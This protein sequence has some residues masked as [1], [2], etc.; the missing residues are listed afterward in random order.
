M[1]KILVIA[2]ASALAACSSGDATSAPTE[3]L[4][5]LDVAAGAPS[6]ANPA[7]SFWAVSGQSRRLRIYYQPSEPGEDSS[8]LLEFKVGAQSLLR[9]PDG[10]AFAPGDSILIHVSVVDTA[11]MIVAFQPAGLVFS[12]VYPAHLIFGFGEADHDV[13]DDGHVTAADST[14][15]ASVHLWRQETTGA[16]WVQLPTSVTL[17]DD[18]A[19]SDIFSFTNYALAY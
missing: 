11:H 10:S 2:A 16:P 7:D 18:E 4:H 1:R 14:L 3:Q 9:R 5:F 19:K 13:D 17:S 6:L 15:L 12:S 8:L